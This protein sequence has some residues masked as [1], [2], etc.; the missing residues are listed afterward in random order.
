[1]IEDFD[2]RQ[3]CILEHSLQ[4]VGITVYVDFQSNFQSGA[5]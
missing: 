3:E 5:L 2:A 1:M 4:F